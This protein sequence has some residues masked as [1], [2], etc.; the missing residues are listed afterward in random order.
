[1]ANQIISPLVLFYSFLRP[2]FLAPLFLGT[3]LAGTFL[4]FIS[5]SSIVKAQQV[6]E[7]LPPPPVTSTTPGAPFGQ[8]QPFGQPF[9]T[10]SQP[11]SDAPNFESDQSRDYQAPPQTYQNPNTGFPQNNFGVDRYLVYVESE[12]PQ[13]LQTVKTIE[14]G[15][16]FRRSGNR[17]IIQAGIFGKYNNAQVRAGQ[18]TQYGL[19]VGIFQ[20]SGGQQQQQSNLSDAPINQPGTDKPVDKDRE[21]RSDYYF[22]AIPVNSQNLR[23]TAARIRVNLGPRP[24]VTVLERRVPRGPHI[25][26]GPFE[27]RTQA[28]QWNNYMKTLG[29]GNARVYFGK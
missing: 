5:E 24:N 15:A 4:G 27:D 25:A 21:Q 17:L 26:V 7:Q 12:S 8:P 9:Q 18:L 11:Q 3:F 16:I 28:E 29:Y 13:V 2:I 20:L 1:M 6:V 10:F 14:P 22:V 23:E 19:A